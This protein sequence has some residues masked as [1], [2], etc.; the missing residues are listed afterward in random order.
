MVR[1][2]TARLARWLDTLRR[3]A[4]LHPGVFSVGAWSAPRQQPR[5]DR[6]EL[7]TRDLRRWR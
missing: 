5:G 4:E 3:I 2:L 6:H 7:E 1:K